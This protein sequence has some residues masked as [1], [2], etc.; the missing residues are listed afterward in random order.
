MADVDV[1]KYR[2]NKEGILKLIESS[3]Y[4]RFRAISVAAVA[5]HVPVIAVACFVGEKYGF[6]DE[7][8]DFIKKLVQ[9]YDIENIENV[10]EITWLGKG[11]PVKCKCVD[12]VDPE[13]SKEDVIE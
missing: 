10:E 11:H 4:D 8:K 7:L 1:N 13:E 5:S 2:V 9:F 3:N 6:D 12:C